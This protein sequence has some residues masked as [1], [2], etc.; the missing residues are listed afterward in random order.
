MHKYPFWV[1]K[2]DALKLLKGKWNAFVLALFIP[3]VIY[4]A[5]MT[6]FSMAISQIPSMMYQEK[7]F[8][9]LNL[10]SL[11]FSI[12]FE[13]V[14][15]GIYYGLRDPKKKAGCLSVY[16]FGI[17]SLR[18]MLPTFLL[19]LILPVGINMLLG[20][21]YIDK[22]YD[23]LM[24]SLMRYESYKILILILSYGVQLLSLY[25]KYALLLVPCILVH[26]PEFNSIQ[27]MKQSFSDTKGNKFYLFFLT[28]SFVGWMLLGTLAFII[29][30]LWA[31]VYMTAAN[32]AYYR[33]IY[34]TQQTL[35]EIPQE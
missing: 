15:V 6:K 1:L 18:K 32:Y 8:V 34:F 3:F 24:F 26:H 11:A 16:A 5:I 29:G 4:F 7:Y 30:I 2:S 20:S 23:Y 10:G 17:K 25:L 21:S 22:F 35:S 9:Y 28:L 33:R 27:L 12:V 31:T 14:T 13:L 19:G